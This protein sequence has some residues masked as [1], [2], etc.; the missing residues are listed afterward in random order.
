MQNSWF[1]N[2]PKIQY[3]NDPS[4]VSETLVTNI[5]HYVRLLSA[6]Q[7]NSYTY[8]EYQVKDGDTPEIVATKYYGDPDYVWLIFLANNLTSRYTDWPLSNEEFQNYIISKYGSIQ[9]ASN[10]IDHYID[11]NGNYIDPNVS[12][13]PAIIKGFVVDAYNNSGLGYFTIPLSLSS[14]FSN[15]SIVTILSGESAGQSLTISSISGL[16]ATLNSTWINIPNPG[17]LFQI[18]PLD[19]DTITPVSSYD[20]EYNLNEAKRIIKLI[21][22]RYTTQISQELLSILQ[23][24]N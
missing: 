14:E 24:L 8:Y 17:D 21:D 4:G 15:N 10:Q 18:G 19:T 6:I 23:S 1:F 7:N 12:A 5:F 16:I 2:F 11:Q 22:S 20:N 3:P 9:A 13:N